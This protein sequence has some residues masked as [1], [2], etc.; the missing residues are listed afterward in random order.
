[1]NVLMSDFIDKLYFIDGS[2]GNNINVEYV[3][4]LLSAMCEKQSFLFLSSLC[5]QTMFCY[6][7][8]FLIIIC[9]Y[10]QVKPEIW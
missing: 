8:V 9:N 5:M 6:T 3:T 10:F 4:P 1:M 2:E 7:A